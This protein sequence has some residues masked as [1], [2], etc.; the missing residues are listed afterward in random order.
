MTCLVWW[1]RE[2]LGLVWLL[3]LFDFSFQVCLLN[4]SFYMNVTEFRIKVLSVTIGRALFCYLK[5]NHCGKWLGAKI[6]FQKNWDPV[7]WSDPRTGLLLEGNPFLPGP[8]YFPPDVLLSWVL[9]S[10]F[11]RVTEFMWKRLFMSEQWFWILS[12][13]EIV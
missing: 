5:T 3:I 12:V 13:T 10:S 6:V 4:W 9:G 2:Y 8:V 7:W 11:I 1:R